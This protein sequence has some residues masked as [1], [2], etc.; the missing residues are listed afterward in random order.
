MKSF[1][2]NRLSIHGNTKNLKSF[3]KD[4][5][6]INTDKDGDVYKTYDI[7]RINPLPLEFLNI[8]TGHIKINNVQHTIWKEIETRSAGSDKESGYYVQHAIPL[9]QKE[10]DEMMEKY[11]AITSYNWEIQ[12]YGTKWNNNH[13]QS[14]KKKI[15]DDNDSTSTE[16]ETKMQR[17]YKSEWFLYIVFNTDWTEPKL[18][19][20][21]ITKKYNLEIQNSYFPNHENTRIIT[22]YPIEDRKINEINTLTNKKI[23]AIKNAVFSITQKEINT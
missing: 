18:L 19:L 7:R 8:K 17:K 23:K 6:E 12:N 11:G 20:N 14:V 16:Y 3:Y 21:Y 4:I 9:N 1:C 13:E 10:K 5:E 22:R 2:E 15:Y